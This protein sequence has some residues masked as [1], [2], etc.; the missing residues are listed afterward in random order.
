MCKI[1]RNTGENMAINKHI[2]TLFKV[3]QSRRKDMLSNLFNKCVYTNARKNM[4]ST[5][6]AMRI[7][8]SPFWTE[9]IRGGIKEVVGF[10]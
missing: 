10:K 1:L 5:E 4:M 6:E 2:S 7:Q 3:L 9:N 8:G